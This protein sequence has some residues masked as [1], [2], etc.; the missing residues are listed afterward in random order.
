MTSLD[1]D[2]GQDASRAHQ[3][4]CLS[5][6]YDDDEEEYNLNALAL[7][8]MENQQHTQTWEERIVAEGRRYEAFDEL[9]A[10]NGHLN[11][12]KDSLNR[13]LTVVEQIFRMP[14]DRPNDVEDWAK[15]ELWHGHQRGESCDAFTIIA[16]TGRTR[17]NFPELAP[18][19]TGATAHALNG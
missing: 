15:P 4:E 17:P 16:L 10:S 19:I 8:E 7:A 11:H 13:W 3:G 18:S 5:D 14:T 2:T 1:T 9:D 6:N 12:L